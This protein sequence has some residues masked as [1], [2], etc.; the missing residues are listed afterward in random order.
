VTRRI[1]ILGEGA[2]ELRAPGEQWTGC[3]RVLLRRLFGAPP[4]ALL[5]FEER[6]LSNFRRDLDFAGDE[7][8]MRGESDQARIGRKLAAR[9]FHGLVVMRDD[10]HRDRRSEIERGLR[11]A[12]AGGRG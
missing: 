10:D 1:L 5:S 6:V 3:G 7:S 4:E 11:E 2:T 8:R 9:D 12:E